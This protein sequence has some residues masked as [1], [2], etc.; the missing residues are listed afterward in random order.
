[1]VKKMKISATP[2]TFREFQALGP[3]RGLP[4]PELG[5]DHAE[6]AAAIEVDFGPDLPAFLGR[7]G[8]PRKGTIATPVQP[9]VV[10]MPPAFWIRMTELAAAS[11][12]SLHGAMREALLKWTKEHNHPKAG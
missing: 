8:R 9:R 1:M 4:V 5:H 10:K 12:L 2:M 3:D 11:G 6:A 7:K